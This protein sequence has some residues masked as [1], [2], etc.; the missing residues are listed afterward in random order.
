MSQS[1][2]VRAQ[3]PLLFRCSAYVAL[4]FFTVFTVF[5]LAWLCYTSFKP[6]QDIVANMI[7]WPSTWTFDNFS[8]AWQ[9]GAFPHLF[10]NSILYSV[11]TTVVVII[12][13][14]AAGFAF[15]K[16]PSRFTRFWFSFV[17]VGLLI[18]ISSS[19][20]PIFVAETYLGITNTRIGI[21]IPYIAFNISFAIYLAWSFVRSID[22]EIID[23]ARIDGAGYI[24][25]YW[26]VVLPMARPIVTTIGIFTFQA[27]WVEYVLV[28]MMSSDDTIRTVQV[29]LSMLHGQLSYNF[30]L[31]FA[32]VMIATLPMM[33]LY[34]FFRRQ[35]QAGF[36]MGSVKG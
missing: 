20:V 22:N 21:I 3:V 1:Q 17:L 2:R 30:G 19:V 16:I 11:V 36:S 7:A 6:E 31:L 8:Q 34:A 10:V 27:C 14:V 25:I 35:L 23:A 24:Q 15:A 5:P 13:S 29:G 18:T 4:A 12:L 32:A 9:I 28:Y 33:V 26:S